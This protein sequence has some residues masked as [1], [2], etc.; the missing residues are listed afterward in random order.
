[1]L[2]AGKTKIKSRSVDVSQ[3]EKVSLSEDSEQGT[4][5]NASQQRYGML[6]LQDSAFWMVWSRR[7]AVKVFLAFVHCCL[8]LISNYNRKI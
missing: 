8:L 1:V 3:V 2:E 4:G 6:L 7:L 5:V